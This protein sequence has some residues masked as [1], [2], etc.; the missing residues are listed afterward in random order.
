MINGNYICHCHMNHHVIKPNLKSQPTSTLENNT[1]TNRPT[2]NVPVF[3][4]S[5]HSGSRAA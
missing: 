3:T 1:P 4:T 5:Q 2:N